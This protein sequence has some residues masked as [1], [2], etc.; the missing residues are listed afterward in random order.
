M[1]TVAPLLTVISQQQPTPENNRF[2]DSTK[3]SCSVY[4][5]SLQ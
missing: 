5:T 3:Y 2:S 4:L 1:Y